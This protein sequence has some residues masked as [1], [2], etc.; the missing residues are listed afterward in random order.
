MGTGGQLLLN[1]VRVCV[2]VRVCV[3][4]KVVI[5][6]CYSYPWDISGSWNTCYVN[7]ISMLAGNL[8]RI[9]FSQI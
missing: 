7:D 3:S 8:A 2:C 9:S 6:L 4:G 5:I 1:M